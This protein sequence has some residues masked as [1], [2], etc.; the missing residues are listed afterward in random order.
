[1]I[2]TAVLLRGGLSSISLFSLAR[3]D[4][5][6]CGIKLLEILAQISAV[7]KVPAVRKAN[8]QHVSSFRVK[9]R[10]SAH[11]VQSE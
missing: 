8:L 4:T 3:G 2:W 6:I 5:D 10:R 7:T 11:W 1:M 9:A